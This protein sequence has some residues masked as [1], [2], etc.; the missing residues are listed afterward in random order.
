MDG[1]IDLKSC[2]R[3]SEFDVE[4]N[5]G[6]QIQVISITALSVSSFYSTPALAS[7]RPNS[8]V[9]VFPDEGGRV[10]ALCHDGWHQEKLDR[11][12]KEVCPAEQLSRP[13]TVNTRRKVTYKS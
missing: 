10:H 1:E 4:K 7:H 3:V 8:L 12:S 5:Y 13:H 2:V 11:G 9:F 6:F